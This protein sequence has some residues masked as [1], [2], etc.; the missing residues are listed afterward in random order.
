MGG[1]IDMEEA[2]ALVSDAG[3]WPRVRDFLWDFA[4]QIHQSWLEGF[5]ED[6][7]GLESSPR[8]KSFMLGKLGVEPCF[9]SF[10]KDDGSRVLLIDGTMLESI[11]KWLGALSCADSLRRVTGGAVVRN[12]KS[13]LSGVYPDV[14]SYV[15]Y[16]SGFDMRPKEEISA[17]DDVVAAGADMLFSCLANLPENL[18]RRL[19]LKLPKN[20]SDGMDGHA[21]SSSVKDAGSA[22][23]WRAGCLPKLL[24]LKFPEAFALCC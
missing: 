12:L 8:I 17:G 14:F 24:R 6:V 19:K 22:A 5:G 1:V 9:H 20:I 18:L 3:I 4:P 2:R 10:P 11:C 21:A 7:A 15:A 23:G 13:V 16:F